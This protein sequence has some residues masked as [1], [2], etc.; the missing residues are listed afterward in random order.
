MASS[1]ELSEFYL[2]CRNNDME[3]VGTR[4]PTMSLADINRIEPNGSTALHAAT[5]DG[6]KEIVKMLL[7]RGASRSIQNKFC[8]VPYDEASTPEI[9]ELFKR[10]VG[11]TRF[12]A[13][14]GATE[15]ICFVSFLEGV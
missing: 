5:Y 7:E 2:A 12:I 14:S 15:W 6:H 1:L 8:C 10:R 13:G 9:K 4:L 3:K 11:N